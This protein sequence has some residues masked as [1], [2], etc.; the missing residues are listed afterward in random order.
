MT[1]IEE[2]GFGRYIDPIDERDHSIRRYLAPRPTPSR[3]SRMQQLGPT[4]DQGNFPKCVTHGA[5]T[6]KCQQ[7][8]RD[9][10]RTYLFDVHRL[11]AECKKVDGIPM[12]DG[13]FTRVALDI[14]HKT[15]YARLG[16]PWEQDAPRYK[17]KAYAR[18]RT[19]A[20][21]EEAIRHIGPVLIGMDWLRGWNWRSIL[22]DT[23]Q[24]IIPVGGHLMVIGAYDRP[25][26][27]FTIRNSWGVDAHT[28]GNV[29]ITYREIERQLGLPDWQSADVWSVVDTVL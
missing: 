22:L 10:R 21:I 17:I 6:V 12:L 9:H 7:E 15:G 19:I 16:K 2:K 23:P 5:A 29:D 24:Q 3:F 27:R 25:A 20:E 26:E 11:Y 28:G 1:Y 14:M 4:L 18:L 13:T 8:R